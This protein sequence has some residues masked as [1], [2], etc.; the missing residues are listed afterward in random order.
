M[1][2]HQANK[3]DPA[4]AL[5]KLAMSIREFCKQ[6]MISEDFFYSLQRQ[7]KGPRMMHVGARRLVSVEEAA[8]WR[9][10]NTVI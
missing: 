2:A 6:H 7:G 10:A 9:E 3:V 1:S 8:R 4:D 5:P